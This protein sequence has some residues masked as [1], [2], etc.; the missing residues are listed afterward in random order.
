M[1]ARNDDIR[2]AIT[3]HEATKHSQRS[4]G[5]NPH[6][7]DWETK[8]LPFKIYRDLEPLPLVQDAP[9]SEVPA[10]E[11]VAAHPRGR[12]QQA[13]RSGCDQPSKVFN[14]LRS[15]VASRSPGI[16]QSTKRG[17]RRTRGDS[18]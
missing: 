8:P 3:Y 16:E 17:F 1:A 14:S 15:S 6:F 18:T 9:P 2:A 12:A 4:L 7:L 13:T 10:P 11:A 5:A